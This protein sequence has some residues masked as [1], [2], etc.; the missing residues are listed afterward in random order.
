MGTA[1]RVYRAVRSEDLGALSRFDARVLHSLP[2]GWKLI[3]AQADADTAP[4]A[5]F[6][7][8]DKMSPLLTNESPQE[9]PPGAR[10]PVVVEFYS[11]VDP[12]VARRLLSETG[13]A[14]RQHPDLLDHQFLA[15]LDEP[16]AA[17]LAAAEE[18][19]WIFPASGELVRGLPVRACAGAVAEDGAVGSYIEKIGEGWDGAGR[20]AAALR[21][22]FQNLTAQLPE[23]AVRSEFARALEAWSR[24]IQV[25][26][27]PG[28]DARSPRHLNVLFGTG[29]HGDSY[30]FDGR[31]RSLAHT[32]FPAPPNQEPIAG[33]VHFDDD[34]PWGLGSAVDYFSVALHETGHALGLGHADRPGSVM[35]AYYRAVEALT[36][37][38][39]A[40]ARE[41]YAAREP[42]VAPPANPLPPQQPPAPPPQP[43]PPNPAPEPPDV[44]PQQ[45]RAQPPASPATPDR[46][47]PVIRIESPGS[48]SIVTSSHVI[49]VRGTASDD[50]GI[51]R[52]TWSSRAGNEGV[53]EGTNS[54][55][56]FNVPLM[57]G[58]NYLIF[59]AHDAAGNS[60][61][62][63]L[64]VVRR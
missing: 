5:M 29:A 54:W 60:A 21:Y 37:D 51:A 61:W 38:D 55:S 13:A 27:A 43:A 30:P 14:L 41:L 7:L 17:R 24:V 45:P 31:G 64:S 46:T 36:P 15:D 39:I 47:P 12:A 58:T 19:A 53:A 57:V 50:R 49:H 8:R 4:A 2:G 48:S 52:V 18:V 63:S 10:R 11:D 20:G 16:S 1:G 6:A 23:D 33:D 3:S 22:A 35:Y 44:P 26:F 25:D 28:G 42:A 32:F 56:A 62:R 9:L 34:E 59:R 40:A